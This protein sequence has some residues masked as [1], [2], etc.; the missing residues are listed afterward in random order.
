[1]NET[2]PTN[3][4]EPIPHLVDRT[5]PDDK[6]GGYYCPKDGKLHKDGHTQFC[7]TYCICCNKI[8][9]NEQGHPL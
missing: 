7:N 3:P 5:V 8:L 2:E 4:T 6:W 9:L 1:M